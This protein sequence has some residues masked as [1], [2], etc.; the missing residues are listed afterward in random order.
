MQLTPHFNL[1]ELIVSQTA[2]RQG[3]DN[4]LPA[5]LLPNMR[6]LAELLE[7]ARWLLGGR[8]IVI[9]SGYRSPAV[10]AL[11]GGSATSAHM[12]GRA[13]DFTCPG[14]GRPAAVAQGLAGSHLLFDQLILEFDAWVHI[15]VA[16]D[17]A[18]PRRQLLTINSRG[19]MQGLVG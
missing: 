17:G 13:A 19:T 6:R 4:S 11:V 7:T 1:D 3:L 15:S 18:A 9:S 14:F 12:D 16:P 5:H 8:P 2:A 10:N